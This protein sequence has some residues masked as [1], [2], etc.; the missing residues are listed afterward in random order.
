MMGSALQTIGSEGLDMSLLT[1]SSLPSLQAPERGFLRRMSG[2]WFQGGLAGRAHICNSMNYNSGALPKARFH[3]CK[4]GVAS[5]S[6]LGL[7]LGPAQAGV[8]AE[9]D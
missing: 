8:G 9:P 3:A 7:L 6:P 1:P 5:D 2:L 4:I